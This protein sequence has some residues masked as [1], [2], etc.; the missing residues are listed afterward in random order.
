MKANRHIRL[1]MLFLAIL[2]ILIACGDQKK[3]PTKTAPAAQ[4]ATPKPTEAY[5]KVAAPADGTATIIGKVKYQGT[6]PTQRAINF[7]AELKCAH[8][9]TD[10]PYYEDIVVNSNG[11]LKD[12]LVHIKGRVRGDFQPP[13]EP[14]VIDQQGCLFLPRVVGVMA[15][16]T[17]E[18][19]NSDPVLHN[20]RTAPKNNEP[21]NISQPNAGMKYPYTFEKP[22][23]GIPLR[24]DVHFWMSGFLHVLPHPFFTV[25][26]NDGS[27]VMKN[28]PPRAYTLEAWHGK[29][30]SKTVEVTVNAGETKT[31]EFT[32]ESP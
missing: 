29:L 31:V 27:F 16:Q 25:T 19:L 8:L 2:L 14:F 23:V 20:V 21:F 6:P 30:G 3:E 24:C 22:E 11:T 13:G 1:G 18:F 17:V 28:V 15:G 9:H 4:K 7:G 10:K 12:T 5:P 26:G 32:F